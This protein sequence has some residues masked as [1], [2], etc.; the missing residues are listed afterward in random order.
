M[1]NIQSANKMKEAIYLN[2]YFAKRG[3]KLQTAKSLTLV[4]AA[5]YRLCML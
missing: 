3:K 1:W 5:T 4:A 2:S